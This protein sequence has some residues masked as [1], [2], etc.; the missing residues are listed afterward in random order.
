MNKK[1][2]TD[3]RGFV[4]STDPLFHFKHENAIT[5]TLPPAKQKLIIYLDTKHRG[6]KTVTLIKGFTGTEDDCIWLGK[7][8][9]QFCGTG[10][11]A[12]DSEII[13][14]GDQRDKVL[15]WLQKNGYQLSK[16]AGG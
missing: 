14:Q 13:I 2:K 8:L 10:G 7:Q 4:Y 12:K 16:K 11:S 1:N 5:E 9:K 6:G 3:V 15:Q